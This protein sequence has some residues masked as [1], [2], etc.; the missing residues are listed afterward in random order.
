MKG[1]ILPKKLHSAHD[2]LSPIHKDRLRRSDAY[3]SALYGVQDVTDIMVLICGHGG[4]DGRCGVMGPVL[5]EEFKQKLGKQ[6][7]EVLEGSVPIDEGQG[8]QGRIAGSSTP[9]SKPTARTGLISHIGG[10]KYAGN[11]IIYIPPTAKT[12]SGKSHPL[13]GCG[14]WYGRVEPKH[15]EGIISKTI[16]DGIVLEDL[17]RG[18]ITQESKVFWRL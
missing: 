16:L 17:F 2:S 1:Y 10:H 6:G 15:V 18:G 11:V 7:I 5:E 12:P 14:I 8:S 9:S 4:R 13:A 3:Q